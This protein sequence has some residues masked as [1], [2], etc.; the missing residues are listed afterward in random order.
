ML[1]HAHMSNC[2]FLSLTTYSH[3]CIH[4]RPCTRLCVY[5]LHCISTHTF[6]HE[7]TCTPK[8][9]HVYVSNTSLSTCTYTLSDH[10]RPIH[11]G[12]CRYVCLHVR[13]HVHTNSAC[14]RAPTQRSACMH[15]CKCE[16]VFR[17]SI[18]V[19]VYTCAARVCVFMLLCA[20]FDMY[21][22]TCVHRLLVLWHYTY[23]C[24]LAHGVGSGL[25]SMHYL[26]GVIN[27]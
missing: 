23:T 1:T 3:T 2:L 26:I 4:L 5:I 25:M 17:G 22:H 15:A 6:V 8:E 27:M 16:H 19:C 18:S 20:S 11:Y 10:R 21:L 24:R 9:T 12:T 7:C 14:M 13:V